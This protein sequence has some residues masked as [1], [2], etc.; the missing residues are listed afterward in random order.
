MGK[1]SRY[2]ILIVLFFHNVSNAQDT[3][4]FQY[5]DS[6]TYSYYNSGEWSKLNKLGR[7]ATEAGI[8]FKH[9]RQRMGYASFSKGNF[10]E[11][12]KQ[13]EKALSFDS[14]DQFSLEYLYYSLLNTGKEE[15]AGRIARRFSTE[16]RKGLSLRPFKIVESIEGEYNFKYSGIRNRSNPQYYRFGVSTRLGYSV[17]L[18]QSVSDYK[19]DI[20]LQQYGIKSVKTDRQPEYYAL[21]KWAAMNRLEL[22]AGYHYVR[23]VSEPVNSGSLFYFE[24]SPD[25][26]RFSLTV[27]ASRLTVGQSLTYQAGAGT[28]FT[29]PGRSNIYLKSTITR[30]FSQSNNRFV[31]NH[32]TGLKI[33][34]KIW[35]ESSTTHGN[36]ADYND[37]GGLYIY[38]S[39]DPIIFRTAASFT[40]YLNSRITLWATYSI[41]R[42]EF[43][44]ESLNNYNQ[45]S[46]LGGIK[47]KL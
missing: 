4:N 35:I 14:Y 43:F 42:K 6:L 15:H 47:W 20:I 9:L 45:F 1:K 18:F 7:A 41:E 33:S 37:F 3:L 40:C 34:K 25:L 5:V 29:F 39:Y 26:N 31:Y 32:R 24:A 27:S 36:L 16:L 30:V 44:G 2:L 10:Y 19:Q 28:G 12:I 11:A 22:K 8:D 46:Y 17:S 38:N 13:F 21:L 23:V